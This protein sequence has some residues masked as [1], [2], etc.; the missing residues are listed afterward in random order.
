M[1]DQ[2]FVRVGKVKDAH[3]IKGELF[4]LLFAGEAAW[5]KKLIQ[6]RLVTEDSSQLRLLTPRS[7]RLHKNG[8]IAATAEILDR[9]EAESLK[10]WLFEIPSE[11]LVSMPGESIYLREIEGFQVIT[12]AQGEVGTIVGFSSNGAQ[13]LLIV[14]TADGEFEVPFVSA[15]V[16][17]TDYDGRRIFLDLPPGLLGE[18]DGE[19]TKEPAEKADE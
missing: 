19:S 12:Q 11:F 14:K 8:L 2:T 9:N 16:Q 17:K 10:G 3:G 13:D 18:K 7:V 5:L 1:N 15:F 6:I 4:L